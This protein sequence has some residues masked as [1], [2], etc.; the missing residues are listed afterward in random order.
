MSPSV[1][2]RTKAPK[3]RN[4]QAEPRPRQL[5][6]ALETYAEDRRVWPAPLPRPRQ[7]SAL[8]SAGRACGSGGSSASLGAGRGGRGEGASSRRT[9]SSGQSRRCRCGSWRPQARMPCSRPHS[10]LGTRPLLESAV[11]FKVC[12]CSEEVTRSKACRMRRLC[13]SALTE[14]A[15]HGRTLV[16][17]LCHIQRRGE[18]ER[19]VEL[20]P[21]GQASSD[22]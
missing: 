10:D 3:V 13:K 19:E 8:S 1:P 4:E 2:T 11:H 22:S 18:A 12:P 21:A 6:K 20:R 14:K 9:R 16:D 17:E 7:P 15:G 5:L